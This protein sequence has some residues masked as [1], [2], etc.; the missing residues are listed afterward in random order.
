[1]NRPIE[2]AIENLIPRYSNSIP[3]ALIELANSIFVQSR[4]KCNLRAEEE[5]ARAYACAN[6]ACERLKGKLDLPPIEPRPPIPPRA[7]DRLYAYL[8]SKLD[9]KTLSKKRKNPLP[10]IQT[11]QIR[12]TPS[13]S[14]Q[15][16]SMLGDKSLNRAKILEKRTIEDDSNDSY[17]AKMRALIPLWVFPTIR[18][19]CEQMHTSKA[20]PHILAGVE[21][22][23][24][25]P[26]PKTTRSCSIDESK[27]KLPAMIAAVWYFV[28]ARMSGRE[29]RL[30]DKTGEIKLVIRS[31]TQAR[32]NEKLLKKLDSK[33]DSWRGWELITESDVNIWGKEINVSGWKELD[34]WR[35]ITE[36]SPYNSAKIMDDNHEYNYLDEDE[37]FLIDKE[38]SKK[39]KSFNRYDY[40]SEERKQE[41]TNWRSKMLLQINEMIT[42]EK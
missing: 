23:L 11:T 1:M 3:N 38:N 18:V 29:E 37:I 9:P 6:L 7:Y 5:I 33:E 19:L 2:Q 13:E 28:F 30:P 10:S 36:N 12:A 14:I 16:R 17:Q 41:F 15:P 40:L 4:S 8:S 22:I 32:D 25:L 24:C 35:N 39:V 34:W 27:L 42:M 21:S 20:I 31:L 26:K